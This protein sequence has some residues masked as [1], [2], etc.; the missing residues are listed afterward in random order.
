MLANCKSCDDDELVTLTH[1]SL[2][3]RSVSSSYP[4][5]A[6]SS[7]AG[8]HR[9]AVDHGQEWVDSEEAG[10][11]QLILAVAD[12]AAEEENAA[13]QRAWVNEL[14]PS[15]TAKF[16]VMEEVWLAASALDEGEPGS[17]LR[18]EV[19]VFLF[20]FFFFSFFFFET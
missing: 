19:G 20:L 14:S 7:R 6:P 1:P 4:P 17:K 9:D 11:P 3:S 13:E 10:L 5:P 8:T 18:M 15:L 12:G 16:L 2:S